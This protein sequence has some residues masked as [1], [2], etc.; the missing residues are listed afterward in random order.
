MVI[1]LYVSNIISQMRAISHREVSAIDDAEARYRAEAGT[2]KM[3]DIRHCVDDAY[4]RLLGRCSRFLKD[5]YTTATSD[6]IGIPESYVIELSL[7]ER[8][9]INKADPLEEAMHN[10]VVEYALSKFYS[11]VSQGDLSNKHSLAALDAG[12]NLETLLYTK[13]PPRV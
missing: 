5:S 8:R 13:Q 6:N 3:D 10:F 11:N 9:A 4:K 7:S 12:N 2:E 1:T